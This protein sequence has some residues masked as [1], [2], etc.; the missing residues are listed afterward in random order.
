MGRTAAV[1]GGGI[2]GLAAAIGLIRAGWEVTVFERSAALP[3]TGTG[4]GI[5]PAALRALDTLGVG[6]AARAA[7]RPQPS[8]TIRRDDGTVIARL[9][10]DALTRRHGEPVHLV[11]RPALLRTLAEALPDG[12]VRFGS[13]VDD[14]RSLVSAYSLVVGADGINSRVRAA[15]GDPARTV[16]SGWTAWRGTAD[17]EVRAGGE[18]WGRARKFGVTPMITTTNWYAAARAP[19][20]D[21]PED[22]LAELHR[23]YADWP[24]PIPALLARIDPAAILHHGLYHLEPLRSFVDGSVALLGDAAH[25]MTP[26]LGQGACQALID[27]AALAEALADGD[28][29]AGLRRYDAVRRKPAQR[30]ARNSARVSVLTGLRH[31]LFVRDAITKIAARLT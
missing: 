29:P 6:A 22:H 19:E 5:W 30:M 13:P 31:G 20:G 26:E 21:E 1:V 7:G 10:M 14:V 24:D 15:V 3:E 18:T 12:I 9:D 4:L 25:A 16:Y 2:G 11:S 8:G 23:L 27:A 28:V 17:L